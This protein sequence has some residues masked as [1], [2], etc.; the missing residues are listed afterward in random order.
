LR[1][2]PLA[3]A[4]VDKGTAWSNRA[5]DIGS[6]PT[7]DNMIQQA[8]WLL[9]NQRQN[10]PLPDVGE[11]LIGD[12]G[13]FSRG[14]AWGNKAADIGSRLAYGAMKGFVTLLQR[15][16]DAS[17]ESFEHTFGPGPATMSDSD[18]PW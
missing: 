8:R 13:Q 1:G 16:I 14:T 12:G 7:A 9:A 10:P 11:A 3:G 15:A 2:I 17:R 6:K 4:Y 5:A 18:A